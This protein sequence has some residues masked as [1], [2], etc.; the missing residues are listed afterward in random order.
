MPPPVVP[1]ARPFSATDAAL[2][3][4][5][6]ARREPLTLLVWAGVFVGLYVVMAAGMVATIGPQIM[7][8][9]AAAA[10]GAKTDP[11]QTLAM[12]GAIAPAYG[13]I[14]L[15][16]LLF[17][18]L[19]FAAV[20]RAILRPGSGAPGRLAFGVDELLQLAVLLLVGIVFFVV[21][22]VGLVGV[23]LLS[24]VATLAAK[25]AGVLVGVIGVF[26]VLAAL[27]FV[28]VRLSLASPMALDRR[29]L[30][31]VGAWKLTRGRFWSLFGAYALAWI[32][33]VIL[34]LT[35]FVLFAGVAAGAGGLQAAGVIFRPDMTSLATYFSPVMVAWLVV[36]SALYAVM[37]AVLIGAP[38]DAYRQLA[39]AGVVTGST[40]LR[41]DRSTHFGLHV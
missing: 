2:A 26:A 35:V 28:M 41:G 3:G 7:Q 27:L 31:V 16:S 9:Q 13:M 36:G 32:L 38:A 19:M 17:Y 23:V 37:F 15:I 8:L 25:P 21:Y 34:M 18:G 24:V 1:P 11:T 5:R 39:G 22:L 30:D 14:M 4:L 6:L 33:T 40:V 10:S 29:S 20:N 12:M